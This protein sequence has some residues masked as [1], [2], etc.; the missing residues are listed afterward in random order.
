[1]IAQ[2]LLW[3]ERDSVGRLSE[4]S[5]NFDHSDKK[6]AHLIIAQQLFYET[7]FKNYL[8]IS[9]KSSIF[10]GWFIEPYPIIVKLN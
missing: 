1:M 8:F 10:A 4:Y 3:F 7:I 6:H 2:C 5:D 9:K